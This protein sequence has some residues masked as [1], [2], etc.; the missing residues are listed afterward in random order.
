MDLDGTL[1]Y[2]LADIHAAMNYSLTECGY[3]PQTMDDT[4]RNVGDGRYMLIKRSMPEGA[5]EEEIRAVMAAHA[6]YYDLHS[7]DNTVPYPG[8]PELLRALKE[9]G[10]KCAC[11]TNKV[12]TNAEAM[13]KSYF[14]DLI[15][16]TEG[17]RPGRPVK[18]DPAAPRDAMTA[19]GVTP[20][21]TLFVGDSGTDYMTA[22]NTGLACVLVSWG[23][24]DR[25]ELESYGPPVID[26]AAE[27]LNYID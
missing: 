26:T 17:N 19:L 13:M 3:A 1:L 18:P 15:I 21:R 14:G 20:E 9:R 8:I 23:Y 24:R 27:L 2:T 11:V 5:S 22:A 7:N 25:A 6:R 16:H 4:R 12:Q 10:V